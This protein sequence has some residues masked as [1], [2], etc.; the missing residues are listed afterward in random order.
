MPKFK[1]D[2]NVQFGIGLAVTLLAV[3]SK[4]SVAMPMGIPLVVGQY[5]DSWSNFLLFLYA[6][7]ATYMAAYSSSQPGWAAPP[8]PPSVVAA[9]AKVDA[10]AKASSGT[11][12][13]LMIGLLA[14]TLLAFGAPSTV[15]AAESARPVATGPIIDPLGLNKK[16][17]GT[18][19]ETEDASNN[20]FQQIANWFSA[21]P[22][23]AIDLAYAFPTPPDGNGPMC[24]AQGG[25]LIAIIKA[26]P[27]I[28][29]GKPETDM[30]AWRLATMRARTICDNTA[31]QTIAQEFASGIKTMSP[32]PITLPS[33]NAF[34][35]ICLHVPH[36]AS[37]ALPTPE[38]TVSPTPTPTPTAT[39]N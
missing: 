19:A 11:V 4:G 7:I 13:V 15:R 21:D 12:G 27:L 10:V 18:S 1:I 28:L 30:E 2:P 17:A 34:S 36:L 31:C 5:I 6:P 39:G 37:V 9:Q 33:V 32:V 20:I 8:D 25:A 24:W 23:E 26:H 16:L 29:T 22:Q 38:P 3:F 14:A 35:D